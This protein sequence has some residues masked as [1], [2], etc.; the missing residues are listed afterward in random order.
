MDRRTS[1][2]YTT[3]LLQRVRCPQ[4]TRY[5]GLVSGICVGAESVRDVD[6]GRLTHVERRKPRWLQRCEH[7]EGRGNGGMIASV[8][9]RSPLSVVTEAIWW[10][11]NQCRV[12]GTYERV[13]WLAA[14]IDVYGFEVRWKGVRFGSVS[15]GSKSGRR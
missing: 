14:W 13:V 2:P 10:T 11:V 7:L 4:C 1:G 5:S 8:A 15:D 12:R 3:P 6:G 9:I